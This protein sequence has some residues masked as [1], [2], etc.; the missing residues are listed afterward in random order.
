MS[1]RP[2]SAA[3][4]TAGEI[5]FWKRI[6]NYQNGVDESLSNIPYLIH[7]HEVYLS[8]VQQLGQ[9]VCIAI[10]DDMKKQLG[11]RALSKR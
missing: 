3:T 8:F 7:N 11:R 6:Q 2:L 9:T 1:T 4:N 5:P 10:L